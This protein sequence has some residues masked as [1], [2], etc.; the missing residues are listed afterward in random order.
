MERDAFFVWKDQM[1]AMK[2]GEV[3]NAVRAF[4][5]KQCLEKIPQRALRE[6]FNKVIPATER[7]KHLLAKLCDNIMKKPK[8]AIDIWKDYVTKCKEGKLLDA[9]RAQKL[10]NHFVYVSLR[11]LK[12]SFETV[13]KDSRS[14]KNAGL[15]RLAIIYFK[16]P[17]D[18]F[19]K[20]KSL[21]QADKTAVHIKGR[22][23]KANKMQ[24]ALSKPTRRA[25]R[26]AKKQT[27]PKAIKDKMG[28]V[29]KIF[30]KRPRSALTMWKD[31]VEWTKTGAILDNLRAQRLKIAL[32]KIHVRVLR[33][34]TQRIIGQGDKVLGMLR[35]LENQCRKIPR[36]ALH[37][38]KD[39]VEKVKT[40]AI[41]DNLRAQKLKSALSQVP[42]RV[43]KDAYLR[44]IGQGDKILAML[45][46]LENQCRKVP[47][48]A[49]RAW[50]QYVD[51]VNSGS[52]LDNLRAQRL[53]IALNK[54]PMRI[55]KD[56]ANRVIG[57]GDIILGMLK[58][59]ENKCRQ[60]PRN[61]LWAWK[62]YVNRVKTGAILDNLRA[63]KLKSTLNSI[64]IRVIK[65]AALRIIGQGDKVLAML[66]NLEAKCQK[67]P[68]TALHA[69]KDYVDRVNSGELLD[70][71]RAQ[72]LK[73]A[74]NNIPIRIIKDATQ[75]IIGEGD[76]ILG[77]LKNLEAK[78][79]KI[80]L[81]ALRKWKE[82]VNDVNN[83]RI[84]DNSRAKQLSTFLSFIPKRTFRDGHDRIIGQGDKFRGA[85]RRIMAALLKVVPD[86]FHIWR[87]FTQQCRDKGMLDNF[88]C[89]KLRIS[90][91]LIA[92]RTITS[93]FNRLAYGDGKVKSAVRCVVRHVA[94]R[95]KRAF[96]MW[97][98]SLGRFDHSDMM[99][100]VRAQKLRFHLM[101]I[102]MRTQL[103]AVR[104]IIGNGDVV[105]GML[106]GLSESCLLYTS[107][108]ADE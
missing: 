86:A 84:F 79:R 3:L 97:R 92:M 51:R 62:D 80:P 108:A 27:A 48:D 98:L 89:Q 35:N 28:L 41:L 52:L 12:V 81:T 2:R 15:R 90:G 73:T 68:R 60:I 103:G 76:K 29:I 95:Y 21:V 42:M 58:N 4:K 46:N 82:F 9:V 32:D 96:E 38:W 107:D 74:L 19:S 6:G 75:R 36:N 39:Y 50:K 7:L 18:A 100:E 30:E 45:R 16:R 8:E 72:K 101:R 20:W 83:K 14:A 65:D 88:R 105:M 47:R 24:S 13:I 17:T 31:F 57:Q 70:N 94:E 37:Q 25:I 61:A 63:Q 59:L 64:P 93:T 99:D 44:V 56:A 49:L 5:L 54:V 66:K 11:S 69:W 77:M 26:S 43:T 104:R 67:I 87:N 22:L 33:D 91:S 106:R 85:L 55:I 53:Q 40:G 71:I 34:S 10:K 23:D 102:P 1:L 78:C